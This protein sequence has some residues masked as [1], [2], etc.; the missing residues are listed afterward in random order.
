MKSK[1][2]VDLDEKKTK[3]IYPPLDEVRQPTA[4]LISDD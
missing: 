4:P 3:P 2:M 1:N